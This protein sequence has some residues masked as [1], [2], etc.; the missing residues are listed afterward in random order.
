MN[1]DYK[2]NKEPYNKSDQKEQ[3]GEHH[4]PASKRDKNLLRTGTAVFLCFLAFVILYAIVNI[5][6]LSA[7]VSAVVSVLTPVIL[8]FGIAYLLNPILKFFELKAYKGIKS[9]KVLR[10]LSLISTYAVTLIFIAAVIFLI[11]PRLFDSIFMNLIPSF[12]NYIDDT[13]MLINGLINEYLDSHTVPNINREQL[14]GF[15]ARFFTQ[16]GDIFQAI[17][18]Y[19][20]KYGTGLV[21]GVKNLIFSVFISI[22]VLISKENLKAQTNKIC[23]AFLSPKAKNNLYRY[24]ELCNRTFGGFLVG[25][26]IDSLIIGLITLGTLFFFDMPFY[27]LVSTIVC[28]TNVIPVFG[29]FIGAI[30]SFF[31]IFIVDPKKALLFL[32]LILIIQQLDGNVI[33]PKILG[34]STGMGSLGVMVSILIMGDLFGVI[35]MILGVPIFAVALALINEFAE[36]KLRRK[37]LPVNTAEYYP[38]DSLVDPYASNETISHKIFSMAGSIFTGL[39]KL[40]FKNRK[41]ADNE[42]KTVNE[43]TSENSDGDTNTTN[44]VNTKKE[45]DTNEQ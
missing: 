19:A 6:S 40:M 21:V 37:N 35:G 45:D 41:G 8:G 9:K 16:S 28:I 23:T 11:L 10:A 22:Y 42:L 4:R 25:K 30:P 12:D 5:Q 20:I 38:A 44:N 31:I 1:E 33:G 3:K 24:A 39:F 13:I 18:E 26:I 2:K 34:N 7:T 27:L 17:G 14:L 36:N 15:V 43:N 32:V 29:P